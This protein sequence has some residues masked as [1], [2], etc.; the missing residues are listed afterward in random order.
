MP[1]LTFTIHFCMWKCLTIV[2]YD[3]VKGWNQRGNKL[4]CMTHT[5]MY[6]NKVS[7]LLQ[8][9]GS[10]EMTEMALQMSCRSVCDIYDFSAMR[11]NNDMIKCIGDRMPNVKNIKHILIFCQPSSLRFQRHTILKILVQTSQLARVVRSKS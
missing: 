5:Q 6:A 1:I 3:R 2:C 11:C 8:K 7:Y 4:D 10:P 9:L